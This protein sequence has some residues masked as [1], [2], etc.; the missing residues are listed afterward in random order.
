MNIDCLFGSSEAST[1]NTQNN[2]INHAEYA[3]QRMKY[4]TPIQAF[5]IVHENDFGADIR[6]S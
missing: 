2:N 1:S 4:E 3:I 5:M 6:N